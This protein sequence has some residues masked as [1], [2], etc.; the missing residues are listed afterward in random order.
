MG[1][2]TYR[3]RNAPRPPRFTVGRDHHG[4]WVV[5]DRLGQVGGLFA[6]EAAALHFAADESDRNPAAVCRAPDGLTIELWPIGHRKARPA[7]ARPGKRV[8]IIQTRS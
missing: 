5:R 4:C 2:R 7:S 6:S 8:R 3:H 1:S